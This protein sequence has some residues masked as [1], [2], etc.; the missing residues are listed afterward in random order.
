M[1][2]F[3]RILIVG[4]GIAGLTLARALQLRGFVPELIEREST[5]PVTGAGIA[6]Q[7]N[8]MWVLNVLG[9]GT[10]V[11]EKGAII[12]RWGFYDDKGDLLFETDLN[13]LWGEAARFV[14][15]ERSRL[16]QVLVN[17]TDSVPRRLGVAL[18]SLAQR[19]TKVLANF[20]DLTSG[21][22]D[23]VVGGDGISSTVRRLALSTDL[24]VN[25]N[26]MNW[27]SIAPIRPGG[28]TSLQFHVG[29][30]HFF[31]LCP[32][33]EGRTYG[34]GYMMQTPTHDPVDGRLERLRARFASLGPLVQE[35]L[36]ALN[37]DD[38]VIC[39][40]MQC[41][42]E[43]KWYRGRVLL[44]GDAAHASSPLMGQGGCMAMEDALI[45]AEELSQAPT[46]ENALRAYVMRRKS[47]VEW[48][49]QQS[50][51]TAKNLGTPPSAR[52]PILRERG[53]EMM[54]ARF[55]PLL[56]PA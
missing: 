46:L 41:L 18:S 20:S 29:D 7:P 55:T 13:A 19:D 36:A 24:P 50:L 1:A 34:F 11:E 16:H 49:Q 4:G 52:N 10:S 47:R 22:Y 40:A 39:S 5:W 53:E 25:L 3:H 42:D 9:V 14:G 45:L 35:Y 33:G 27:R 28:L 32:V 8:G 54:R 30:G 26:A 17:A 15:I 12:R 56:P 44:I 37:R 6:V 21:E 38:Q 2:Q 48:V 23:L 51:A 43:A 31:G